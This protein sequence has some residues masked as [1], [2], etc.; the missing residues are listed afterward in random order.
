MSVATVVAPARPKAETM[1]TRWPAQVKRTAVTAKERND[2]A[3]RA[4]AATS[5]CRR[6]CASDASLLSQYDCFGEEAGRTFLEAIGGS[7]GAPAAG[8]ALVRA[9]E[10]GKRRSQQGLHV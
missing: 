2:S 6:R 5:H 9:A 1:S 10:Q 4:P 8:L 7:A 3:Q